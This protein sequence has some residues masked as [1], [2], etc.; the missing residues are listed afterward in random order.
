MEDRLRRAAMFLKS[1]CPEPG[2]Q[3]VK[4]LP[5]RSELTRISF[6]RRTG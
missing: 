1:F 3:F 2:L 6:A 4:Q 5:Y